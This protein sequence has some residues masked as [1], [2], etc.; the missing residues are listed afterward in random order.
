MEEDRPEV[1]H[2]GLAL[3]LNRYTVTGDWGKVVE[4]Y[5][6][7]TL[8]AIEARINTSGDTALHVAVSVAPKKK[9]ATTCTR[10]YRCFG[11]GFMDKK[12]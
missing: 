11:V 10:N 8:A 4:M 12:Q 9:G 3:N 1:D 2:D 6:Q 5:K 7:H